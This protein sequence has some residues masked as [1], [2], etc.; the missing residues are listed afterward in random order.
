MDVAAQMPTTFGA[1]RTSR[2]PERLLDRKIAE[3]QRPFFFE[4]ESLHEHAILGLGDDE[5]AE[6]DGQDGS[7]GEAGCSSS[8]NRIQEEVDRHEHDDGDEDAVEVFGGGIGRK[9]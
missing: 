6:D 3:R 7:D 4:H 2:G 9:P 1:M 5:C 8:R